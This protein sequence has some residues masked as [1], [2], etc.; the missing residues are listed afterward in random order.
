MPRNKSRMTRVLIMDDDT[1]VRDATAMLLVAKGFEVV[2]V[3]DGESGVDAVRAGAFDLVIVDL[4]MPGMDGL[5]TTRAIRAIDRS[6]PIIAVSGFMLGDWRLEMPNFDAM[7]AEAGAYSTLYK[8]FQ[9]AVL[10]QAMQEALTGAAPTGN[11]PKPE[12]ILR[13][14]TG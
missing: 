7:A 11:A 4:F 13:S 2:A 14:Q 8:P 3:P 12:V 10:F 5:Q 9:P 1:A 6:V